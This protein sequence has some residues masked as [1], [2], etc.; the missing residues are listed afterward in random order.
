MHVQFIHIF[1]KRLSF[2]ST[3]FFLLCC[4]RLLT[5]FM[6]R[7]L[8]SLLHW[9]ICLFFSQ[10]TLSHCFDYYGFTVKSWGWLMSVLQFYSSILSR[11]FG[12]FSF[13]IYT[14]E[15]I[16][17]CHQNNL[18]RFWLGLC[19][20]YRSS[21]EELTSWQCSLP[22]QEHVISL[23][24]YY[25][26]LFHFIHQ[27][28]AFSSHISCTYFV[29]LYLSISFVHMLMSMVLWSQ[30]LIFKFHLFIVGI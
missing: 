2:Y 10:Y 27:N 19:W 21:W 24:R 12:I 7:F 16:C 13:S 25:L 8:R 20:M 30:I 18:L 28:F 6:S 5:I 9:S 3:V 17:S 1:L 22:I 4:Q 29:N 11:L 15:Y 26:V 14:L 23:Q